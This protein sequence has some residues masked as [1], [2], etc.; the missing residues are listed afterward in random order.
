MTGPV[1]RE[2]QEI[3]RAFAVTGAPPP[4]NDEEAVAALADQ[5]V[6]VLEP[7]T[8]EILMAPPFATHRSGATEVRSG[9]RRWWSP[10]AWCGMGI[11]AALGLHDAVLRTDGVEIRVRNG[12]VVDDGLLLHVAVPAAA[13]WEDMTFT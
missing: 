7:G 8:G 9:V 10:C 4:V 12:R 11:V 1:E 3:F 13:W 5:R 2:R 6:V